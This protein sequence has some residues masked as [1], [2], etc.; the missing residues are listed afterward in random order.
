MGSRAP[1]T[2]GSHTSTSYWADISPLLSSTTHGT[3]RPRTSTSHRSDILPAL[4]SNTHGTNRSGIGTSHKDE[5]LPP[6]LSTTHSLSSSNSDTTH[7]IT[8]QLAA[9]WPRT[10][11]TNT[12]SI[13]HT[14]KLPNMNQ[15]LDTALARLETGLPSP[16]ACP[17]EWI[18]LDLS[19][20]RTISNN[21]ALVVGDAEPM[22]RDRT[23]SS[24]LPLDKIYLVNI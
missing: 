3:N 23:A 19:Y 7:N 9:M 14:A 21:L 16:W 5:I 2:S 12:A 24:F 11:N 18:Y 10:G 1:G 6:S 22:E 15:T 17:V 4:S 8:S 20:L 13:I